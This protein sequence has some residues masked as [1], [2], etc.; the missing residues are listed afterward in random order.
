[1]NISLI[2]NGLDLDA[3]ETEALFLLN[4]LLQVTIYIRPQKLQRIGIWLRQNSCNFNLKALCLCL[5]SSGYGGDLLILCALFSGSFLDR[6]QLLCYN[7]WQYIVLKDH[8]DCKQRF[9]PCKIFSYNFRLS[10]PHSV[11]ISVLI[12]PQVFILN[13]LYFSCWW[14]KH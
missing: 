7:F 14:C 10:F 4:I 9:F 2:Y 1:M 12:G 13:A 5:W 6:T 11:P 3:W 8:E